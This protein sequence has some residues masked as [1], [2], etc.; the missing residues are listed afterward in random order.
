MASS[1]SKQSIEKCCL[2]VGMG[3][4][5]L[6]E[7]DFEFIWKTL[8]KLDIWT[9]HGLFNIWV[10]DEVILSGRKRARVIDWATIL[11][12]IKSNC[13]VE[14]EVRLELLGH[15]LIFILAL[16]CG[17]VSNLIYLVLTL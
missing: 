12:W 17:P 7:S 13:K 1:L 5:S 15:Y 4:F 10:D 9:F 2:C 8:A 14:W 3:G 6:C 16:L 11:S